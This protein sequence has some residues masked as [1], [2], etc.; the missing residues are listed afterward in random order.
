MSSKE[1]KQ[2]KCPDSCFPEVPAGSTRVQWCEKHKPQPSLSKCCG[3]NI[4]ECNFKT[5]DTYF[6]GSVCEKCLIPQFDDISQ[7]PKMIKEKECQWENCSGGEYC[8]K[9]SLIFLPKEDWTI[10]FD[11]KFPVDSFYG[12]ILSEEGDIKFFIQSQIEAERVR[13]F[14]EGYE[15]GRKDEY[16]EN[17]NR[18]GIIS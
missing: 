8:E 18:Y 12:M 4:Q 13:A 10:E 7:A 1:N 5:G 17:N 3:A 6:K 11:K 14:K 2:N 9:H 16:E 15:K